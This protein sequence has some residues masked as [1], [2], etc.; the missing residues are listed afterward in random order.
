MARKRGGG[1]PII[2]LV[3]TTGNR[4]KPV[5]GLVFHKYGQGQIC[6]L[7]ERTKQGGKEASGEP[8]TTL[9]V[10]RKSVQEMSCTN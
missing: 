3:A 9:T 10:A 2:P 4:E 7:K 8:G 6:V 5:N 1:G